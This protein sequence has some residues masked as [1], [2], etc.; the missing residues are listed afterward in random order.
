MSELINKGIK[1]K[2]EMFKYIIALGYGWLM[3]AGIDVGLTVFGFTYASMIVKEFAI[4][5]ITVV[6]LAM[7]SIYFVGIV[8]YI[9][10]TVLKIKPPM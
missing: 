10:N 1:D 6:G 8:H 3:I 5:L 2:E 7:V 9:H 4:G